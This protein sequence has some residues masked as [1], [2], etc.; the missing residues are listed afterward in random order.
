MMWPGANFQYQNATCTFHI[1][2][3]ESVSWI[4]RV[5][6]AITWFT[7]EKTPANL[8]MFYIEEPDAHAHIYGPDSEKV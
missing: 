3:N 6:T 8:V 4:E 5:D 1:S 2:F 7:H